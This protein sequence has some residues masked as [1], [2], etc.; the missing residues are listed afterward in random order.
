MNIVDKFLNKFTMY[1]VVLYGLCVIVVWSFVS[2]F[3]GWLPYTPLELL[4]TILTLILVCYFGNLLLAK[5]FKA[6]INAESSII[7]ALILYFLLW[8]SREVESVNIFALA[9]IVAMASKYVFA[10]KK[11]HIFNPAAVACVA[12]FFVQS[13]GTWWVATPVMFIPTLVIGLLIVRKVRKFSM[14]FS[15]TVISFIAFLVQA[16]IRNLNL[17]VEAYQFF[18]SFPLIFFG[19]VMLTEP[20]TTPPTKKLQILYSGILG[21]LFSFQGTLGPVVLTTESVLI[22]GNVFSFLVSPKYKF[23]LKLIAKKQ[24]AKN[25]YEYSFS[26][27][28]SFS[29]KPGQYLEWTL[30]ILKTDGRGNRRYFT[31]ASSPTEDT[32]KLSVRHNDPSSTFKKVLSNL[33]QKQEI[34]A[35]QLSGDFTLS[36]DRSDKLVFIAGGIGITPFRSM[37]KFIL[38]S[39]MNNEVILFYSNKTFDEI[40]YNEFFN[41]ASSNLKLKVVHVLTEIE[42]IPKNWDGEKGRIDEK[43]IRKYVKNINEPIYYISGPNFMVDSY[44]KLLKKLEISSSSIKTD[45]FPGF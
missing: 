29:F 9:G 12:L 17:F 14:F 8:P 36:S 22:I 15:F 11:K 7:T 35:G 33:S 13:G 37:I 34:T 16:Q 10:F 30:P 44:K 43:M 23:K 31:I 1:R 39:K 4:T 18:T 38:D 27:P 20:L 40:A 6:T 21:T 25:T 3:V 2:S 19:T 45:Y 28:S 26:R 24:I 5:V 42:R 41:K 32:I